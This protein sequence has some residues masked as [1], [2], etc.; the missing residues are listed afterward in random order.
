MTQL[1]ATSSESLLSESPLDSQRFGLRIFRGF[2]QNADERALLRE[3]IAQSVDI[4]I[5]RAP[6]GSA[7]QL[8]R[9]A[10]YGM[11]P[12][13]AD[14]LVYYQMSL[15][16]HAPR[17][18]RNSDLL[19]A[20]AQASDKVELDALVASTFDGYVSH[21]HANPRLDPQAIL[22]GYAE[23]ATGY[24]GA[25]SPGKITWVARREGRIVAFACCSHDS[26]DDAC[27]GVL[28]GVHPDHSGGGLYGDLIRH[29]QNQFRD[30]GF[31][32]MKVSTQIWNLAVQKVWAREGFTLNLAYDTFHI[33]AMLSAGESLIDRELVFDAEQVRRFAEVTGDDNP[34][35][36]EDE[37]AQREGFEG[38]ITH[39]MLAGGEISRIFGTEIP[40]PGTLFLR[41][42]F[43]F[44][45][46]VYCGRKHR[47]K[48]RYLAS[49]HVGGHIPA[50]V[51]IH[52]EAGKLCLLCYSD[53]LKRN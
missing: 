13:S 27:E 47:L 4:A 3:I 26:D 32:T 23:W 12:I 24:I 7:A 52:D 38:R 34:I 18:L 2:V 21:Y 35:H 25:D 22:A 48:I 39:G 20:E 46:P 33:N 10:R 11:A 9:L 6:A 49:P 31:K 40:G 37:S 15:A 51:T 29:T 14:T 28:Y 53:L 16:D 17:P 50:V 45:R 5:V 41:S 8:H 30:R 42:D 36:L 19:F 43:I 1:S 44:V